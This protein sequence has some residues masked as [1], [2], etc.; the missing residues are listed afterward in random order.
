MA[1][2]SYLISPQQMTCLQ[3]HWLKPDELNQLSSL[4]GSHSAISYSAMAGNKIFYGRPYGGLSITY[5]KAKTKKVSSLGY[6]INNRVMACKFEFD[7]KNFVLFNVYMPCWRD[8]SYSADVGIICGFMRNLLNSI[9]QQ[10][11]NVIIAGDF[12]V[13]PNVIDCDVLLHDLQ[14]IIND[15]HLISY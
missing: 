13:H 7:N 12:N 15:Y 6:S 8:E 4:S 3:E 5:N 9:V 14:S 11:C 10:N 2:S 1:M